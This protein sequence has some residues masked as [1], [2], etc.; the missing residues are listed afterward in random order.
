MNARKIPNRTIDLIGV[1]TDE[2]L[3]MFAE[4]MKEI[5]EYDMALYEYNMKVKKEYKEPYETIRINLS[6]P[7]GSV[8]AG[9]GIMGIM[10]EAIAPI[11]VHV[12]GSCMS[13]GISILAH[14]ETRSA[15]KF[16][17]FMIHGMGD[18]TYGYLDESIQRLAYDK[19]LEKKLNIELTKR[20]NYTIE[21][22]ESYNN[23]AHFFGYEE[24]LEKGLLTKDIYDMT[25]PPRFNKAQFEEIIKG[26][27]DEGYTM[28]E[29][30]DAFTSDNLQDNELDIVLDLLAKYEDEFK[31]NEVNEDLPKE[32]L[33]ARLKEAEESEV[34]E[35]NAEGEVDA[36]E[37]KIFVEPFEGVNNDEIEVMEFN[38]F[39]GIFAHYYDA[40][41][42][43]FTGEYTFLEVA[44]QLQKMIDDFKDVPVEILMDYL[45]VIAD[46][47]GGDLDE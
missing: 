13:M 5:Q 4:R 33:D 37:E 15:T 23:V 36:I 35:N 46:S 11:H 41:G 6:T 43:L 3:A 32:E 39:V 20:T 31:K 1:V 40:L 9:A 22:L 38:E 10:D 21:E 14:A 25:P 16:S 2:M 29:V 27:L 30:L 7:G 45:E 28:D 18:G 26:D 42:Y 24:A 12:I 17:S 47:D 19:E 8:M 34:L 44:T